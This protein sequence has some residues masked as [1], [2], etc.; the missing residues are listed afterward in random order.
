MGPLLETID[1]SAIPSACTGIGEAGALK[2]VIG[3]GV[4]HAPG[5][6]GDARLA[7]CSRRAEIAVPELGASTVRRR[8][9]ESAA[10]DTEAV[11]GLDHLPDPCALRFAPAR[12][13][14]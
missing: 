3:C 6:V 11:L 14:A 1:D 10:D 13:D 5:C 4:C 8:L 2:L 7:V 9:S 12:T